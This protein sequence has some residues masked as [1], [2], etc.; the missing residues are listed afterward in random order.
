[1]DVIDRTIARALDELAPP[2]PDPDR[3][4]E[5]VGAA[6]RPRR[7]LAILTPVALAGVVALGILAWPFAGGPKGTILQR[8][9]AAIGDGPVLHVVVRDGFHATQTDLATGAQTVIHEQEEYWYD[10]SQGIRVETTFAGVEQSDFTYPASRVQYL[11][12]TLAFLATDYRT[13]LKNGTAR[14]LGDDTIDGMPVYWIRVDT[15]LK[16]DSAD[17]QLHPWTHDVAVAQ[18]SLK[19]IATR[20]MWEGKVAPD[21]ISRIESI[22]SLGSDSVT[23]NPSTGSPHGQ[24]ERFDETGSLTTAQGSAALGTDMLTA[25]QSVDGLALA[26]IAKDVHTIDGA[27]HIGVTLFYGAAS[28]GWIGTPPP[29][30]PYLRIGEAVDPLGEI[31]FGVENYTPPAGTV[32]TVGSTI[33]FMESHGMRVSFAA[34][35]KDLIIDAA[36]A[37]APAS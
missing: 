30:G 27:S 13:A 12:K 9:A 14:V 23:I 15:E 16:P 25:G 22:E 8:A 2:R 35:S 3:W 19:P 1:M 34:S 21:G 31:H 24:A 6:N 29:A 18:S 5:I 11:D 26:R 33:G 36:K 28:G 32:V 4:D 7:R 10:P 17:G 37:L 20:E